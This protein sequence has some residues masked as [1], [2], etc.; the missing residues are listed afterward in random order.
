MP[1]HHPPIKY[2][3]AEV[4][5]FIVAHKRLHDGNSPS[6]GDIMEHFNI[7]S[8]SVVAHIKADLVKTGLLKN[9]GRGRIETVRGRWV[10]DEEG[11]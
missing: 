3:R 5:Q 11:E 6:Y 9:M 10:L 4:F 7:T 1:G 8:R 2:D